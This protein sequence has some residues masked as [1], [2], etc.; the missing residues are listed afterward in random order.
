MEFYIQAP[1]FFSPFVSLMS[2]TDEEPGD[3]S[4]LLQRY[5]QSENTHSLVVTHGSRSQRGKAAPRRGTKAFSSKEH[6]QEALEASRDALFELIGETKRVSMKSTSQGVLNRETG[7]TT[8]VKSKG[9]HLHAMGH[10]LKGQT[11]LFL[12]EA[13]WLLNMHSLIVTDPEGVPCQF[14]DYCALMFTSADGWINFEKYQVSSLTRACK[15][16][17]IR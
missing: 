10:T 17:L 1:F 13:A 5:T 6:Q 11:V 3:F 12:E 15:L 8:I 7:E 9:A 4:T 16:V 14:E 2:D